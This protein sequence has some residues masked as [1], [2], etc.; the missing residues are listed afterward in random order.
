MKL[1]LH[2]QNILRTSRVWAIAPITLAAA[3]GPNEAVAQ[4]KLVFAGTGGQYEQIIKKTV[5]EPFTAETGIQVV[6][7]SGSLAERWGKVKSMAE[8]GRVEWDMMEL[9]GGEF[10]IP[11]RRALL[12]DIGDNCEKIPK[13]HSDGFADTCGKFGVLPGYGAT[14]LVANKD[15]FKGDAPKSWA[16]FFDTK[17]FPGP[18]ALS[19]FGDPWRVLVGALI[20]DGVP[21]DKLFPID[22]D[23]AFRK[24]DQIRPDVALWWRSGDPVQRA[25]RDKEVA[26]GM[27]W[28]TR[29]EFLRKEGIPLQRIW[30]G[31]SLNPSYWSIF[32]NAPNE[33]NAIRFLNW[34]FDNPEVQVAFARAA[35]LS[36][37]TK[38]ALAKLTPEEQKEQPNYPENQ[39]GL[40]TPDYDW[41]GK[42]ND[43]ML[44]RWNTWMAK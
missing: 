13:A 16:D 29:T 39:K 41:I 8:A 31:A 19:N 44:Q 20:A 22:Y 40:V 27:L 12:L 33:K 21:K 30:D 2:L 14:L 15:M 34:Y 3:L 1:K 38:S 42:N 5:V 10:S 11:D 36:P 23:R 35:A 17:K 43:E 18:R 25:F 6:F 24:L 4:E 32:K 37:S 7:V 28:N 26:V 9:G